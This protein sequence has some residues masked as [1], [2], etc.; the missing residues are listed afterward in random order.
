MKKKRRKRE[1]TVKQLKT[2][3]SIISICFFIGVIIMDISHVGFNNMEGVILERIGYYVILLMFTILIYYWILD[4]GKVSIKEWKEE[5]NK[6][7][8]EIMEMLSKTEFKEVSFQ[9]KDPESSVE[10]L[11]D[12]LEA[13]ECKFYAKFDEG[14]DGI[15][16]KCIDKHGDEVYSDM[17]RNGFYFLSFFKVS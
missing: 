11:M 8:A 15:I 4:L 1:L 17:I 9:I 10:M 12:I 16:I 2:I 7:K 13:E 6:I 5:D 14:R 3:A